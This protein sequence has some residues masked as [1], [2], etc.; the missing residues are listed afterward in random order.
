[1]ASSPTIRKPFVTAP[2]RGRSGQPI[3]PRLRRSLQLGAILVVLW[4]ELGMFASS[5]GFEDDDALEDGVAVT[6]PPFH[7]LVVGDLQLQSHGL[8]R[9]IKDYSV[10]RAWSLVNSGKRI[11][12]IVFLG[13]GT[14]DVE[15]RQ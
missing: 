9:I 14:A 1:M 11:D 7:L 3:R 5:C 2:A 10:R 13:V 12:G 6:G 4:G 8:E 15:L